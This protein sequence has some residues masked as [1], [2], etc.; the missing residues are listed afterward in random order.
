VSWLIYAVASGNA[1][2]K[3]YDQSA[4]FLRKRQNTARR[5]R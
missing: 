3:Q 5:A 4:N 1:G 2:N